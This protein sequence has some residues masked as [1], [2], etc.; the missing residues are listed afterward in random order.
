MSNSIIRIPVTKIRSRWHRNI[1]TDWQPDPEYIRYLKKRIRDSRYLPPIIVVREG[2]EFLIVNG[3]HRVFAAL[4]C[5]E[6]QIK[7]IVIE[8]T[9]DQSAPLR[10]AELLLKGFDQ[11]T[12]Y[13]YRFSNY[14][15]R[16]G[17]AEEDHHFVN[18]YRPSAGYRLYMVI[19]GLKDRLF[20]KKGKKD[21]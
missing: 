16:W 1:L 10:E 18:T 19:K 20:G 4:E 17:A 13:R 3:H 15:D 7:C 8:G 6:K 12:G 9:F 5:G 11:K 14:L 2:D 21:G